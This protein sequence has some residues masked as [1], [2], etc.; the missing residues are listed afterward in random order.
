MHLS[1]DIYISRDN[2][3]LLSTSDYSDID[4]K[5]KNI[6][7][8]IESELL[9]EY[10]NKSDNVNI[11]YNNIVSTESDHI[12]CNYLFRLIHPFN[13][14]NISSEKISVYN[15]I[16]KIFLICL[17]IISISLLLAYISLKYI[18]NI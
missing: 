8:G 9:R 7:N 15:K 10:T 17:C 2:T 18:Y 16:Y 14:C 1:D 4:N 12:V 13:S 3:I 5:N 11:I 6:Y